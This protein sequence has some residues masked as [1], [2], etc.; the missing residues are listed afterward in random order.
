MRVM[1]GVP[2][3]VDDTDIELEF[4]M[5]DVFTNALA[6]YTGELRASVPLRIT[7]KLNTPNPGGP[8]AA[9]VQETPFEFTIPCTP[10]ADPNEGS[11]CTASTSVDALVPGAA[12]EGRRAI[13]AL[14]RVAVYDGGADGDADTPRAT[15]CSPRRGSSFREGAARRARGARDRRARRGGVL[16][17][18]ERED[19]A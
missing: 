15:R 2:G 14:G 7:D 3:G 9:T 8:G 12:P 16:S 18:C 19:P 6:D 10:V 1:P 11:A 5:D 17:R 13:W 4:F